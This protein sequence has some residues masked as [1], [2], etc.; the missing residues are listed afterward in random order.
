MNEFPGMKKLNPGDHLQ[1]THYCCFDIE[2]LITSHE[3]L[4]KRWTE[5]LHCHG[6]A[7]IILAVVINLGNS[8]YCASF[9]IFLLIEVG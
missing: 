3:Q 7:V 4:F 8:R 5:Q 6:P 2:S 1:T 9:L